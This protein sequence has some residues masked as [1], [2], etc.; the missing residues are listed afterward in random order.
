MRVYLV[1]PPVSLCRVV[2][3]G[4][5]PCLTVAVGLVTH[6]GCG[7]ASSMKRHIACVSSCSVILCCKIRNNNK[8]RKCKCTFICS[9]S[10]SSWLTTVCQ[11]VGVVTQIKK[12]GTRAYVCTYARPLVSLLLWLAAGS[13]WL[14]MVCQRGFGGMW[15]MW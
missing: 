12:K 15:S 9:P 14:A 6:E 11:R 7:K 13:N 4:A 2:I 3:H 10:A 5:A 1:C 8:K